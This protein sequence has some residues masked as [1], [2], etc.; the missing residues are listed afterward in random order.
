MKKLLFTTIFSIAFISSHAQEYYLTS[1]DGFLTA[2]I[3]I[4]VHA[5]VELSKWNELL[6]KL[7]EIDLFAADG[8][9]EGMKVK[10][11]SNQSVSQYSHSCN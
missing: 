2:K 4:R 5:S 3:T 1:P 7:D 6:L 9:L 8:Q 10:K 11:S